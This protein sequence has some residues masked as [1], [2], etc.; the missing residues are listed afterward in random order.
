M[1]PMEYRTLE[2]LVERSNDKITVAAF[3]SRGEALEYAK[4]RST[5][6][7]KNTPYTVRMYKAP[8]PAAMFVNGE[9]ARV[10]A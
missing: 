4:L 2:W 5:G 3:L 8:K 9:A 7:R 10:G 1:T 6:G